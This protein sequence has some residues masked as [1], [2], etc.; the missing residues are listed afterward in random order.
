MDELRPPFCVHLGAGGHHLGKSRFIRPL[1]LAD[2][3]PV[4]VEERHIFPDAV[5]DSADADLRTEPPG[6]WLPRH[7]SWTEAETG[8]PL[9]LPMLTRRSPW[10]LAP[11]RPARWSNDGPVAGK[12]PSPSPAK[13]FAAIHWI[14][15]RGSARRQ[16]EVRP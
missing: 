14:L 15:Q 8:S 3:N 13:P 16:A 11:V 10:G 2:D 1:H 5:A 6:S 4:L 12:K 9:F 7:E